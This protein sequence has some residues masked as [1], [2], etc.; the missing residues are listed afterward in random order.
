MSFNLESMFPKKY[1]SLLM[2]A[3]VG[4]IRAANKAISFI[5]KISW[6]KKNRIK[7]NKIPKNNREY[8]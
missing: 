4:N 6:F 1:L 3:K 8:S 5:K 7:E 2:I